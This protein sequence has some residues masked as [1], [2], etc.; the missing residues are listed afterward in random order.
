MDADYGKS[1]IVELGKKL[2]DKLNNTKGDYTLG[3]VR[4]KDR[5]RV[6]DWDYLIARKN[7]NKI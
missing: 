6:F 5:G 3:I 4:C 2:K 1:K 7:K